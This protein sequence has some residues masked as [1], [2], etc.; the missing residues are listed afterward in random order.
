MV[1]LAE[2]YEAGEHLEVWDE[3]NALGAKVYRPAMR[4]DA[5]RVAELTM[6][7]AALNIAT[8][9]VRLTLMGYRFGHRYNRNQRRR[10]IEDLGLR[11]SLASAGRDVSWVDAGD[12]EEHV[13]GWQSPADD[14]LAVLGQLEKTTGPFPL[15]LHAFV[16]HVDVVDLSGSFPSWDPSAYAFDD[17]DWPPFGVLSDPLNFNGIEVIAEFVR[18]DP[19][20]MDPSHIPRP[21]TLSMPV[22]PNHLLSA[23]QAGEYHC[24]LLPDLVADPILEGVYGRPGIRL[25]EYLRVAFAWGGF[26]GFEFAA[27]VPPEIEVLRRGLLPL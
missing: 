21:R 3:L 16:E 1:S 10:T 25:V 6:Q 12:V 9:I 8:L 20:F 24:V 23:N 17:A 4:A 11:D 14:V 27:D 19:A 22:A 26:P 7:R 18:S 5:E 13:M 2:R 15:A